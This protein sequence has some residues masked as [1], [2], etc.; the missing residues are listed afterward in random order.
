MSRPG[1]SALVEGIRASRQFAQKRSIGTIVGYNE[2]DSL[3]SHILNGDDAAVI[4]DGDEYLLLAAEGIIPSLVELDPFFAG[5]SAVLANVNDIY[6]MGGHPTALVNVIGSSDPNTAGEVLRGM[7][8]FA[9]R[10]NVPIVG[11][12]TLISEGMASISLTVLGRARRLITSFDAHPEDRVALVYNPEGSWL[13]ELGFWNSIPARSARDHVGDLELLPKA[14]ESGMVCAGKDISMAGIAGTA[15]MFAEASGLGMRIDLNRVPVPEGIDPGRWLLAYFSY[16]FILAVAGK[17]WGFVSELFEN[18]S[19]DMLDIGH[20]CSG[21]QVRFSKDGDTQV[22][23][24]WAK[25]SFTGFSK[26]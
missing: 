10:F 23:W 4:A 20:F 14:A 15:L 9:A 25:D 26:R 1:L 17:N 6:S 3:D 21:S 24:D 18:R 8:N 16:G 7:R 2:Q 13:D 22:L 12:H 5:R 11:G 19:L